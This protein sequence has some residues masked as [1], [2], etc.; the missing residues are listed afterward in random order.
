ME[1]Y[2]S[3]SLE[4]AYSFRALELGGIVSASASMLEDSSS[5]HKISPAIGLHLRARY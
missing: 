5:K 2:S 4:L 3:L 1:L